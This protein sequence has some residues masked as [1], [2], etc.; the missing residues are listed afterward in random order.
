[1]Y[2]GGWKLSQANLVTFVMINASGAEVTGLGNGFTVQVSKAGAA[3]QASAGTKAEIGLGIYSYLCTAGE[4]NTYGPVVLVVTGAGCIQQNLEYIV[5][6]RTINA[7]AFTYTL[8]EP[9]E[10]GGTPIPGALIW[11]TIDVNGL[12][13][14]WN[15]VTDAFGV[16]RDDNSNLPRLDPGTYYVWRQKA[17]YNFTDPD[18][19]VVS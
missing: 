16:A 6:E 14:V 8:T 3:F 11:F 19:E 12:N 18:T 17:G 1:M 9:P 13:V 15:G 10:G 7:V 5:E 4:A 2:I